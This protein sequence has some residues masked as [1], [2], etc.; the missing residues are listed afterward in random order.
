MFSSSGAAWNLLMILLPNSFGV[1]FFL[2]MLILIALVT[3]LGYF[4]FG[5]GKG[6]QA[7]LRQCWSLIWR[8]E[9]SVIIGQYLGIVISLI[10]AFILSNTLFGAVGSEFPL[11]TP[12]AVTINWIYIVFTSVL[13]AF[14][15]FIGNYWIALKRKILETR[16]RFWFC[17]L[18]FVSYE[19]AF[20]LGLVILESTK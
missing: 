10:I 17:L 6:E 16:K 11:S 15:G 5:R 9:L 4:L 7:C 2:A 18:N 20:F 1:V 14:L 3:I 12:T 19:A 8:S 13:C